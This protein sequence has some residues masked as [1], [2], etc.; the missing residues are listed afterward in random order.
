MPLLTVFLLRFLHWR[1]I[2]VVLGLA[3]LMVNIVFWVFAPDPKPVEEKRSGL[4]S[5]LRRKDF[6]LMVV[7]W[8]FAAMSTAGLYSITPL[9]LVNER[10]LDLDVAN[11]IFGI[12]RV[13]GL[14]VVILMGFVL[15]RCSIKKIML[16][17]LFWA[18]LSTVGIAVVRNFWLLATLL[19]VQSTLGNAL[20][21]IGLLAISKLTDANE[22]SL[23]TGMTISVSAI[24]GL[25][26][27]PLA[28]GAVADLWN[29]QA[30]ILVL[31]VL[32]TVSCFSLR[33]LPEI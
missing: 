29:F 22:R 3:C 30:G 25:G 28:L 13:G 9:F 2:F 33:N 18:G 21:P 8:A 10:G 5:L 31:G 14:L 15:D 27:A 12:S 4:P 16:M 6:R 23:F 24:M 19:F 7:F 1:S 11:T 32:T 26:V 20:F 17:T